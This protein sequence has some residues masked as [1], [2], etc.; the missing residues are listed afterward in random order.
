MI[1]KNRR[2]QPEKIIYVFAECGCRVPQSKLKPAPI[3]IR[4]KCKNSNGNSVSA[5]IHIC[6]K[7]FTRIDYRIGICRM[8]GKPFE[9]REN[10]GLPPTCEEHKGQKIITYLRKSVAK[11]HRK[12][13]QE[14]A[15]MAPYRNPDCIHYFDCLDRAARGNGHLKCKGCQKFAAVPWIDYE[16]QQREISDLIGY[17]YF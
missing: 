10:G 12:D 17:Q 13:G 3:E 9:W 4:R 5:R 1:T 16:V 11:N 2:L 6:H 8:C 15:Q 14:S 7:H